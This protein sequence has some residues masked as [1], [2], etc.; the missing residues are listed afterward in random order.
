MDD[1]LGQLGHLQHAQRVA[2]HLAVPGLA[3]TDVE[4]RFVSPLEGFSRRQAV[5]LGHQPDH[6]D[7][8]HA[9]DEG[10]HLGHVADQS[11]D[12]TAVG[13]AIGTPDYMAPEQGPGLFLGGL[14][15]Q[16]LHTQQAIEAE[17]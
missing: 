6:A 9:G 12:L 3:Q 4:Q 5:Q 10:V 7:R 1:R 16:L 2:L 8:G 11:A 14:A 15:Q 13:S 17:K